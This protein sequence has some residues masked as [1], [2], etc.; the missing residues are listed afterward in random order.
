CGCVPPDLDRWTRSVDGREHAPPHSH[1]MRPMSELL[2]S[3]N[4][5]RVYA[6]PTVRRLH[7]GVWA[8]GGEALEAEAA[9]E[10]AA[11]A[12][13]LA[14]P[15]R[16]LVEEWAAWALAPRRIGPPRLPVRVGVSQESAVETRPGLTV[17][18]AAFRPEDITLA[19]D[20]PV[21]A[22]TRTAV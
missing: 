3:T 21:S 15:T 8:E 18:H 12:A 4:A 17:R 7:R 6:G 20:L 14:V 16:L 9:A 22:A 1:T 13:L 2:L 11:R 10:Q 5:A 19:R